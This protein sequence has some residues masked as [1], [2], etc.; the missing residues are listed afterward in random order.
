MNSGC[1]P[2]PIAHIAIACADLDAAVQFYG[3]ILGC[4]QARRYHDRVTFDFFG[5][6]VVCHLAPDDVPSEPRMYPRH[7][8]M[9]F[10]RSGDYLDVLERARRHG[11]PFH[12]EPFVRFDGKRE[13]HQTFFL[14]DPSNNLVEFKHYDD[15]EMAY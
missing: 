6:Q 12:T 3:D 4:R 15:P 9:T 11:A 10:L 1:P 14:V 8:G 13:R 5:A 7:F 2:P